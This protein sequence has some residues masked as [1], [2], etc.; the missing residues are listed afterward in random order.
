MP[1]RYMF[2][3]KYPISIAGSPYE[4]W[5]QSKTAETRVSCH[6]TFHA[7]SP[8]ER[9][10]R[11]AGQWQSEV[12]EQRRRCRLTRDVPLFAQANLLVERIEPFGCHRTGAF[13]LERRD[14]YRGCVVEVGRSPRPT[15]RDREE[16]PPVVPQ[17]SVSRY[18]GLPALNLSCPGRL[19]RVS[20]HPVTWPVGGRKKLLSHT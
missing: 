20:A 6:R 17:R 10:R 16:S 19:V 2:I 1:L 4:A 18:R 8:C 5:S 12:P 3:R 7:S 15:L 11:D 13:G 9:A 14:L